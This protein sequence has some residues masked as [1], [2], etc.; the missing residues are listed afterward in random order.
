MQGQSQSVTDSTMDSMPANHD[1]HFMHEIAV[2]YLP[3]DG[4][5]LPVLLCP[6]ATLL[7]L[8]NFALQRLELV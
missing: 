5:L 1:F 6:F 7:Q 2:L 8:L 4:F 3:C